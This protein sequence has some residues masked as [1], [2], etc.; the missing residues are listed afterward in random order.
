MMK[1]ISA[2]FAQEEQ[3]VQAIHDLQEAGYDREDISVVTKD[4]KEAEEIRNE[5]G[6]KAP[7]GLAAGAVTGGALGGAAGV[8]AS[9]GALAIPGIGPLLAAGPI[10][11]GLAGATLGAGIGG[12][13][14]GFIGLGIPEQE[15]KYYDERIHEGDVLVMVDADEAMRSRIYEIFSRNGANNT[16]Y[17]DPD[18]TSR[19][20]G[21]APVDERVPP[22]GVDDVALH[23][24]SD[25]DPSRRSDP[26]SLDPADDVDF[27][28]ATDPNRE[29][30]NLIIGPNDRPYKR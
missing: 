10:A 29:A 9:L 5:T 22:A 19:T 21:M 24:E 2:T 4:K 18:G 3:A 17:F 28:D 16:L 14:G 11:A 7:E 6:T 8:L 27:R 25:S 26:S 20:P 23:E 13:A 12:L 1:K 15:A 30:S